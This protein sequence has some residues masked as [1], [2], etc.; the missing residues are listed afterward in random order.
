ML[1]LNRLQV[2][3]SRGSGNRFHHD[4]SVFHCFTSDSVAP[5][6]S[7]LCSLPLWVPTMVDT[8]PLCWFKK[9][10]PNQPGGS[11]NEIKADVE[12]IK[13]H[14]NY[15]FFLRQNLD[16]I[17][18]KTWDCTGWRLWQQSRVHVL[19]SCHHLLSQKCLWTAPPFCFT[20]YS[21]PA[22]FPPNWNRWLVMKNECW[23]A[24]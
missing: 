5:S 20:R 17:L 13:T 24:C 21:S 1:V 11:M 10:K 19:H 14:M 16:F 3:G 2:T 12:P 7:L 6:S 8:L 9:T 4:W 22:G 23:T 15:G 18:V